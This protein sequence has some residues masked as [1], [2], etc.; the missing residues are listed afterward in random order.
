MTQTVTGLEKVCKLK[1]NKVSLRSQQRCWMGLIMVCDLLGSLQEFSLNLKHKTEKIKLKT[2]PR[3]TH[4]DI[5][6][7]L[8][9]WIPLK[10]IAVK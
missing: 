9:G 8:F 3:A 4:N 7:G 6:F 5:K 1:S 10:L 2:D